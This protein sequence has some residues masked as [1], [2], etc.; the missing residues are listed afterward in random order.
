MPLPQ[1]VRRASGLLIQP[2]E[3]VDLDLA[4]LLC[5][6]SGVRA[7]TDW[8]AY[9]PHLG[10]AVEI[11][12]KQL[13]ALAHVEQGRWCEVTAVMAQVD[14][15]VLQGL[16]DHGLVIG[17]DDDSDA[18]HGDANLRSIPWENLAV[19]AHTF[20]RWEGVG[21]GED[22]LQTRHAGMLSL[23]EKHGPAPPHLHARVPEFARL[24]LPQHAPSALDDLL[25]SRV[26]CRNFDKSAILPRA[27]LAAVLQRSFACQAQ[28]QV[29]PGAWLAKKNHPSG[30]SLHPL[31]AYLVLRNVE[32]VADGLYHYHA[33]DHA[34][35]P[36][37]AVSGDEA[38][39]MARRFVAGQDFF[40]DAQAQI[41]IA[42]RFL[43]TFWKYRAH[44]KAYRVVTL[45]VGHVAQNTYLAA[46]ESG[47][48]AYVTAAINEIDI[49]K[50]FGLEPLQESPIAV[51]GVGVRSRQR[52]RVELDPLGRVWPLDA[53]TEQPG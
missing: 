52:E 26:T 20:A 48:G 14:A 6:G 8:I 30:G 38:E 5:G 16:F 19:V 33:G 36:L 40:S 12:A 18:A 43:R 28:M 46:A 4:S 7:V 31:E 47:L 42:P 44:P 27:A 11:D 24:P 51:C 13:M 39:A 34:L 29:L 15:D 2:R 41:I 10:K 23:V 1:R 50:A 49:E 32:D 37:Q 3:R 45:E 25:R 35:E 17:P 22:I 21:D 9:A 53:E